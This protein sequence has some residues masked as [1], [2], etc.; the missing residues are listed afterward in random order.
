MKSRWK[1]CQS[2]LLLMI[3]AVGLLAATAARGGEIL[4]YTAL[5]DDQVPGTWS[6]SRKSTRTSM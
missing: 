3:F 5:E 6:L 4:V 2:M 1:L